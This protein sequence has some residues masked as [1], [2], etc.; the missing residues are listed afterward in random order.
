MKK[1]KYEEM[2]PCEFLEAVE[3]KPVFIV[4]TGLLEWHADHLPLG[5]DSLKAY[6]ICLKLAEK[7]NGG[8]V[9]PPNYYGRPGFSSYVGTLTYSDG[10]L[11]TLFTELFYQLKKVGA[12]VIVVITGHYGDCQVDFIKRV[13]ETFN[14]ENPEIIVIAQ[15]EYEGVIVNGFAPADHAGI[16]ETSMFWSLYP[17]LVAMGKLK[18]EPNKMKIYKNPPNDYYKENSTWEWSNDVENASL[19]LGK[20]AVEIIVDH[21][22]LKIEAALKNQGK[23]I[24][25]SNC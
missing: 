9:L 25:P 20:K 16:W 19:E 14:K 3:Q 8:I 1:Y 6:G 22:S 5:L 11:T 12:K 2:L 23:V 21:L 17:D 15:P 4:P 13:A 18:I 7:I 10:C 24:D